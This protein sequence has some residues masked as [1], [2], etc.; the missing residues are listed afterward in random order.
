MTRAASSLSEQ[1]VNEITNMILV[2]RRFRPGD[3]LPNEMELAEELGISRITLREAIRVLCTRGLVE[4]QRGRGTFVLSG[5]PVLGFSGGG[6]DL[7][8][9]DTGDLLEFLLCTLPEAARCA[10]ERAEEKEIQQLDALCLEIEEAATYGRDAAKQEETF[11]YFLCTASHNP[12]L[13]QIVPAV[14]RV[15]FGKDGFRDAHLLT[16]PDQREMV[17]ALAER[18]PELAQSAAKLYLLH[19]AREN[20]SES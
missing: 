9:A 3:K 1:A 14:N 17:R 20:K 16:V 12:V 19:L 5:G 4:I 2:E 8:G 15:L 7:S 11:L 10:A 13:G 6:P 18:D